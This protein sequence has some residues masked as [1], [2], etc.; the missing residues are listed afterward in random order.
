MINKDYQSPEVY[1]DVVFTSHNY[2]ICTSSTY[3]T[4]NGTENFL[5]ETIEEI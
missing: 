1:K 5:R 2:V 4:N 3:D